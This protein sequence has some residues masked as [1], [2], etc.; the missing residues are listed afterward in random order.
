MSESLALAVLTYLHVLALSLWFGSLF[1]YLLMVWP[2]ITSEADGAFPRDIL[3]GIAMRSAPWIY[4]GMSTALLS[5]AGL[6]FVEGW[7][8]RGSWMVG[9]T[10]LL[11][12]LVANNVYGSMVAWPRIMFLPENMVRREWFWFRVRMSVSLVVG[13]ALFSS[14]IILT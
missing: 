7:P 4:L 1:G 13:L 10:V 5:L 6:W 14:A 2:A 12:A 3:V 9:Y 11:I 8:V